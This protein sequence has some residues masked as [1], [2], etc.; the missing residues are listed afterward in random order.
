M[1][2]EPGA[3]FSELILHPLL[4][5][6]SINLV[7]N[8]LFLPSD[9]SVAQTQN[10]LVEFLI[11]PFTLATSVSTPTI[12][13]S[14]AEGTALIREILTSML[15]GCFACR[16]HNETFQAWLTQISQWQQ[17]NKN[18]SAIKN[19]FL[20]ATHQNCALTHTECCQHILWRWVSLWQ[21]TWDLFS[22]LWG[23]VRNLGH[24]DLGFAQNPYVVFPCRHAASSL[25]DV[26]FC[27]HLSEEFR[28][29]PLSW[30]CILSHRF[31]PI[32]K[33][34]PISCC[35]CRDLFGTMEMRDQSLHHSYS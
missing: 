13:P 35:H 34:I 32:F 12:H 31:H 17:P 26:L 22:P 25:I 24:F 4:P 10:D 7:H 27:F 29:T 5:Q 15:R 30:L 33:H 16:A 21:R 6:F 18:I 20:Y 14:S 11:E 28:C 2:H 19:A 1:P 9:D 8:N 23:Q 3:K